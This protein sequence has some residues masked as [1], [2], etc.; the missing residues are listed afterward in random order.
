MEQV[1]G[2]DLV[3]NKGQSE[4]LPSTE[5]QSGV[6]TNKD[7]DGD[8]RN[9]NTVEG[10]IEGYK[11]AEAN[12]EALIKR[13]YKEPQI[14]DGEDGQVSHHGD[15]SLAGHGRTQSTLTV[16]VTMCPVYMRI[17]PVLAPLPFS[18]PPSSSPAPPSPG[19]TGFSAPGDTST[20]SQSELPAAQPYLFFI[21]LLRDPTNE[22]LHKT[23]TQSMPGAWLSIPF[24]ENE[25]V[26]DI[27]VEIIRRGVEIL[28]EE[29]VKGR[30]TGRLLKNAQ[31]KETDA[32]TVKDVGDVLF[33]DKEESEEEEEVR[34]SIEVANAG[35]DAIP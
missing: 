6:S 33:E 2:G 14:K 26:E 10:F 19:P 16:P 7:D 34:E 3:V 17:Q 22:L 28:G 27:M 13:H 32:G 21:L 23:L 25:W 20:T 35:V 15:K 29:Y 24:E 4:D 12:L 9:L 8:E 31:T 30:M 18:L 11:M 5:K 1:E